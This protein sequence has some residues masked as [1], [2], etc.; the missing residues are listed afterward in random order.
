[1]QKDIKNYNDKIKEYVNKYASQKQSLKDGKANKGATADDTSANKDEP[2][3]N[4][5]CNANKD[6]INC[7]ASSELSK[8]SLDGIEDDDN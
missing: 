7:E 3:M 5:G 6:E 2:E 4:G 1:M 8:A